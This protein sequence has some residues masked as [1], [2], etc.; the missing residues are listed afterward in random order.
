MFHYI[1]MPDVHFQVS[2]KG[3]KEKSNLEDVENFRFTVPLVEYHD[4]NWTWLDLALAIKQRCRRVL[5]QQFVKQKVLR[6]GRHTDLAGGATGGGKD[7][8]IEGGAVLRMDE[9]DKIR[10]LFGPAMDRMQQVRL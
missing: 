7:G 9:A 10:L 1:K 2:Y 4:R 3:V 5:L 8:A 6:G